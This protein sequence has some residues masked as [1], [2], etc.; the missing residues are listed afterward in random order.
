M[1]S[2]LSYNSYTDFEDWTCAY[3]LCINYDNPDIDVDEYCSIQSY[4]AHEKTQM[5]KIIVPDTRW[6]LD[7]RIRTMWLMFTNGNL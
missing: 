3:I 2:I 5:L 1:S 7:N 4:L 6:V